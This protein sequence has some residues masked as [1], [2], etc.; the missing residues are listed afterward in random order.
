MLNCYIISMIG[1]ITKKYNFSKRILILPLLVLFVFASSGFFFAQ[2]AE[3]K[4]KSKSKVTKWQSLLERNSVPESIWA[5]Y[6][7]KVSHGE[8][9]KAVKALKKL[10][11]I[12][13]GS[14][15]PEIRIGLF[16]LWDE[17]DKKV[18]ISSSAGYRIKDKYGNTYKEIPP[19]STVE[20]KANYKK[21]LFKVDNVD[22]SDLLMLEPLSEDGIFEI[23]NCVGQKNADKKINSIGCHQY[24]KDS[25]KYDNFRGKL[26][27]S[28]DKSDDPV[29]W[30]I[31][32]LP[33]E[34]YT[35]GTGE[36]GNSDQD[37]Y[38]LFSIIYRAYGYY[39]I[40]HSKTTHKKHRFSLNDTSSDQIYKG[41]EIE[42]KFPGMKKATQDTRGKLVMYKSKVALTPYCSF[43]D[44][45]TRDKE[46][47]DYLKS[48]KDHEEGTDKD[49]KPG[50]NGNHME[51]LSAHGAVGW[52]KDGKSFE[53][54]LKYYYTG[55]KIEGVY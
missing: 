4:K 50:D 46:G 41:Y 45:R 47:Y 37:Y 32:Q 17:N 28:F 8:Y 24:D 13:S 12:S 5:K 35:W 48:V 53:W 1:K 7:P 2:N 11:Q 18:K 38:K 6:K 3:A 43:T 20:F 22:V 30:L 39:N 34:Q 26:E 19:S 27:L 49:L 54:V 21:E 14:L 9:K 40:E 29:A 16:K 25:T 15:G 51:G 33:L 42:G 55:V 36:I 44:G 23:K 10:G 31:N 52:V